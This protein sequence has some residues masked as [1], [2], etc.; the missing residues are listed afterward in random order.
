MVRVKIPR[1]YTHVTLDLLST[2]N[3][4]LLL[5]YY[6]KTDGTLVVYRHSSSDHNVSTVRRL[7]S[8]S[9]VVEF[10]KQKKTDHYICLEKDS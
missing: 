7:G 1:Q 6:A 3:L 9:S 8:P 5:K 10:I 2:N 4:L